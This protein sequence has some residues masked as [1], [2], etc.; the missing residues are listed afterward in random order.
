MPVIAAV[1][2]GVI[3]ALLTQFLTLKF[4]LKRFVKEKEFG[5]RLEW[6]ERIFRAI[7]ER[8]TL[9]GKAMSFVEENNV[10]RFRAISTEII[11]SIREMS[12]LLGESEIFASKEAYL[13]CIELLSNIEENDKQLQMELA[14][15]PTTGSAKDATDR[16]AA[17]YTREL[18]HLERTKKALGDDIRIGLGLGALPRK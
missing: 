14:Q 8:Q 6:H 15:I 7:S 18:S 11:D 12:K 17:K 16:I 1:I 13:L 2:T 5:R 10:V 9:L 3:S 4:G